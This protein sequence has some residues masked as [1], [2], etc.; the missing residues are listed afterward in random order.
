M[1]LLSDANTV[2][3]DLIGTIIDP[4]EIRAGEGLGRRTP[5]AGEGRLFPAVLKTLKLLRSQ[6]LEL[7]LATHQDRANTERLLTH[8]GLADLFTGVMSADDFPGEDKGAAIATVAQSRP[9]TIVVGDR[10]LDIEAASR[11]GLL[12]VGCA[13]G[14]GGSSGV[15][16]ADIVAPTP[17]QLF[18]ILSARGRLVLDIARVHLAA[19]TS[20]CRPS[21][22]GVSGI[23]TSGKSRLAAELRDAFAVLNRPAVVVS[24]DDFHN[25][26]E[27]RYAAYPDRPL[28]YYRHTFDWQR[29]RRDI[30]NPVRASRT[31]RTAPSTPQW[32]LELTW[33]RF[34]IKKDDFVDKAVS[35][36]DTNSVLIVEGVFL[37]RKELAPYFDLKVW[38]DISEEECLRR[39]VARDISLFGSEREV[40]RGYREK[41]LPGQRIHAE[42]DDPQARADVVVDNDTWN[43]PRIATM[44]GRAAGLN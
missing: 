5:V 7:Y 15:V 37:F 19:T 11:N 36:L 39:A 17:D 14:I 6:G 2:I 25:P 4:G 16:G 26:K 13:Y 24:V 31:A 44:G 1:R 20:E 29:L 34:D 40:V 32:P 22:L 33:Q 18:T 42:L 30:L 27:T 23:D 38:L 9:P 35:R 3:F 28:S 8:H 12:S 43:R 21:L 41:Y 10:G